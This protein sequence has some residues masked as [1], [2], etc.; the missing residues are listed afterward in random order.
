MDNLGNWIENE[1]LIPY[2]IEVKVEKEMILS[3]LVVHPEKGL[4]YLGWTWGMIWILVKYRVFWGMDISMTVT[5]ACDRE[6]Y[7][8]TFYAE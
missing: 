4:K 6:E 3:Y 7:R 1:K 5:K 8:V 2:R